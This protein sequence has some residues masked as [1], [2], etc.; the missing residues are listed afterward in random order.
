MREATNHA[1]LRAFSLPRWIAIQFSS[2]ADQELVHPYHRSAGQ[3][4][5]GRPAALLAVLVAA[6]SPLLA[7]C[8]V[9]FPDAP[10]RC[11]DGVLSLE[12]ECDDGNEQADDGCSPSCAIEPG[13]ACSGEPSVCSYTCGDG[14][15]DTGTEECDDGNEQAD[16]G[17]SPSC[18]MEPGWTCT[19]EPSVCSY[20]CGDGSIDT[21]TEEC[22]D[23]NQ[24]AD[25]GCSPS[26]AMEQGWTCT[27]EPSVCSYTCGDGSIDTGTEECDDGNQ[28][29]DDGCS[30]S[31]AIEQEWTCSGEPSVCVPRCGDGRLLPGEECDDGGLEDGDGCS[32]TC[33]LERGWSCSG[34][35]SACTPI[36]GDGLVVGQE[37]CDDANL[38][39][40]DGCSSDCTVASRYF[41]RHS[42]ALPAI[43]ALFDEYQWSQS[44]ILQNSQTGAVGTYRIIWDDNG[45]YFALDAQDPD[46]EAVAPQGGA[47][48]QD[49]G[50]EFFLDPNNDE[51][52]G[53]LAD[54]VHLIFSIADELA[55][56]SGSA[57][58]GYSTTWSPA[59]Q[60]IIDLG[61]TLNQPSDTDQGFRIELFVSWNDIGVAPPTSLQEMG[62]DISF[63]DRFP[64]GNVQTWWTNSDG[65]WAG[66][67][68][69]FGKIVF[70]PQM[71]Q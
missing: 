23:G 27:G 20:T 58:G 44:I 35:P 31:C 60:R 41:V 52:T 10:Q 55:T 33:T 47:V 42:D 4:A 40:G 67:P 65:G 18:A 19:G 11:G 38:V 54:D 49:D 16:D 39:S 32:L 1:S 9:R 14:S 6:L 64:G 66:G 28:Q 22:D 5:P 15:I 24:Q 48:Y 45:L 43:D 61:G 8:V 13:W 21:G 63:N 12:E 53:A 29:A 68:S 69:G 7:G 3:T 50:M 56:S 2:W 51:S 59:I 26:C 36:C 71:G 17:C 25:D 62:I 37:V 30:P 57:G 34:A 70:L 46:L